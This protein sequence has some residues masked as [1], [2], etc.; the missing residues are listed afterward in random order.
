M[1]TP[2]PSRKTWYCLRSKE[3]GYTWET[4]TAQYQ[5]D[6]LPDLIETVRR[7]RE[8]LPGYEFKIVCFS[9]E[10]LDV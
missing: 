1:P 8:Q 9:E 3:K 5:H 7:F 4:Q 6:E 10:E 2:S